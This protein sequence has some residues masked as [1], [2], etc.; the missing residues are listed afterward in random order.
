ME[1]VKLALNLEADKE[2]LMWEQR[3]RAYWLRFGKL[4][5]ATKYLE[6]FMASNRWND[7]RAL[8]GTTKWI[9]EDMNMTLLEDFQMEK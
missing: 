8:L 1:E 7:K 4:R 9:Q 2:E 3:A 6:L 5:I